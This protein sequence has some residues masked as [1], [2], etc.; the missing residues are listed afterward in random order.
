LRHLQAASQQTQIPIALSWEPFL[1]NPNMSLEGQDME[2]HLV[3]K[4]GPSAR[5]MLHDPKSRLKLMGEAVGIHFNNNRRMINT[6]QA[7]QLMEFIKD[8]YGNDKANALMEQLYERY[9]VQ[10]HDISKLETLVQVANDVSISE[11]DV[12]R[13]MVEVPST[14][15]LQKDRHVKQNLG[16]SG[17]PF[18]MIYGADEDEDDD[19]P[20]AFS[21]AYPISFIADLL[22]KASKALTK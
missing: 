6:I 22:Q 3:Q 20:T 4:Y 2:E 10:A 14:F 9:F 13:A 5:Q 16:V 12:Q 21:G 7:H 17:V 11:D 1:L 19:E 18:F 15:I 8:K